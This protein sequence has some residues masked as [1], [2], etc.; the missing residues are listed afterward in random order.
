[1]GPED[2]ENDSDG[3]L[4]VTLRERLP[5]RRKSET[6]EIK[7]GRRKAFVTVGYY[8]DGRVGEIFINAAKGGSELRTAMNCFAI[9]ISKK[10]QYGVGVPEAIHSYLGVRSN[11]GR[12]D[13]DE[14]LGF[15]GSI[16]SS[17]YDAIAR[18][19]L[20]LNGTPAEPVLIDPELI[21]GGEWEGGQ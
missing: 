8:D 10:I 3:E 5:K 2:P 15:N 20:D 21:R 12:V 11:P 6:F 17:L 13:C 1:M 18:L 19:L 4:D 16:A 14:S 9:A 7:I